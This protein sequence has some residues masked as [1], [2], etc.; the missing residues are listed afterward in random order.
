VDKSR[1][2]D[3]HHNWAVNLAPG[4]TEPLLTCEAVLAESAFHLESS[5]YVLSLLQDEMLRIACDYDRNLARSFLEPLP[6]QRKGSDSRAAVLRTTT[7]G[8]QRLY[9][10]ELNHIKFPL[11]VWALRSAACWREKGS[12][13]ILS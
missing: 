7:D 10:P 1:S 4:L 2:S 3:Q 6:P 9:E 13:I 11:R 5:S 12:S 8:V